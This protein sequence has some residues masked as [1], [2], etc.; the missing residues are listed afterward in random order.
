MEA[1][2]AGPA[3]ISLQNVTQAGL[4]VT[5]RRSTPGGPPAVCTNLQVV[6]APVHH[7]GAHF[8]LFDLP[9]AG[10]H[11]RQQEMTA[12]ASGRLTI[13][14]DCA[15]HLFTFAGHGTGASP[16]RLLPLTGGDFLRVRPGRPPAQ[17]P[18]RIFNP[19][20]VP[21]EDV[22][23]QLRS[24][25][26]TVEIARASS[27]IK[28]IAPGE[29]ADLSSAFAVGF[30]A[31][32][33]DFARVRLQLTLTY[34]GYL[35]RTEDID[36]LVAPD[37][38]P[39]PAE[40]VVIDGRTRTFPCFRQKGNQGGGLVVERTVTEGKGNGNGILEPGEE[41][42]LW[43]R[44]P[45]GLDPFDKNNW[46]RAKVYSDSPLLQEVA[47]IQEEKQREWTQMQNRTS[48]VRLSPQA[49][50]QEITLILDRESW[51]FHF[52]P[53]VRYGAEPLYQAFQL[54]KHHLFDWRLTVPARK[55]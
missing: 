42:T 46:H 37:H 40:V 54:H 48:L 41:A 21:M 7:P 23:A 17:L 29:A 13:R 49:A 19:R 27:Q 31:G 9:L 12:D 30:T 1:N 20:D 18:I 25:Y 33:G 43:V 34:D 39:P 35:T 50:G 47:E 52:T 51:S 32:S 4:M 8:K 2:I 15:G 55:R 28:Q 24:G 11:T 14:S 22:R 53:D 10:G 16:P 5:T 44:L 45:Q 3:I 36:L 38:L 6:T 26:P